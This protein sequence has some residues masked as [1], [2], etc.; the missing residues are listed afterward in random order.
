METRNERR[1]LRVRGVVQGVGF[2]PFVHVL[3]NSL[4]LGG[5]VLNDA[6]GVLIEV[7]GE[8]A[9]LDAFVH[10]LT[11]EAPPLARLDSIDSAAAM[12]TGTAGFTISASSGAG[13]DGSPGTMAW[14]PPD[15]AVCAECLRELFDPLDRRYRH[16][17]ITCTNCGPRFT[18]AVS[19]PY[20]RAN[21]TMADFAMCAPCST[22]YHDPTNRR[23]H[24]QPLACPDCGPQ[25][26][27]LDPARPHHPHGDAALRAAQRLLEQGAILA[28]KGIGGYHLM[29]DATNPAAV[30]E[31]RRRKARGR[32]PFAV[33]VADARAVEATESHCVA[34]AS[35]AE[36]ALL[37]S[38]QRPIVLI[39][40][41]GHR[42]VLAPSWPDHVA[43]GAA[44][45]GVMLPSAPLHHLL[46]DGLSTRVLVCTSANLRD[47]PIVIDDTEAVTRL[48]GLA[49]AWLLHDRAIHTPCDD[50]VVR[51]IGNH[52]VPLRRSRGWAPLP[53]TISHAP[54]PV[55]P[56]VLALGGDLKGAVC[57]AQGRHAWMSQHLG[58]LGELATYRAV[59]S[60]IAQ[61]SSL[62][63]I[64]PEV[65]AI[66]AHPG[67]LSARL[68]RELAKEWGVPTTVVQHHHAH[69]AAVLAERARPT[70]QAVIGVAFDGTGYGF[71]G[72]IWGGEF[73]VATASGAVRAAHLRDVALPGGDAAIEHPARSA[74]AHLWSS[75]CPWDP[76]LAP[77]AAFTADD[78]AVVRTQL[79]RYVATIPTSSMGRLFDAVASLC[80]VRQTVDYEAQAAIELEA[81]AD[82]TADGTYEFGA[83][84]TDGVID[85]APVIRAVVHDVH[86]G[87]PPAT[88]SMRF[89]RAVIALVLHT[90]QHLRSTHALDTAVLT[91]GVFQN[92][93]LAQGCIDA[94]EAD[95][96]EVLCHRLAPPNDGGLALGQA[97]VA[98]TQ[99]AAAADHHPVR[100]A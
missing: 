21:T 50:S 37:H 5:F 36:L 66:D 89:H 30:S 67:Y 71:D 32:K 59:R 14:L 35:G 33:M 64:T 54:A 87:V 93:L 69:V 75:G 72:T 45:V 76:L 94:L 52:A 80:G 58:D 42:S 57:L 39:P 47:E 86:A 85:T 27:L 81:I 29:C 6:Q 99:L 68:G 55:L 12:P 91:G 17:F 48:A 31:L 23:F 61:L 62:T 1:A 95:G 74:L 8:P 49:D 84:D 20:D 65:V 3:A 56:A 25:L 22:E 78:L 70:H 63:G 9:T 100:D 44:D 40:R 18:I 60:A 38:T 96:F 7:E 88:V 15:T 90:S 16:P 34:A 97:L 41:G 2:R 77:V 73:L 46:F 28:V 53:I 82:P 10:R 98:A 83:V 92:A 26:T 4:H 43:P 51:V 24:A 11:A 19:L 79:E 13:P